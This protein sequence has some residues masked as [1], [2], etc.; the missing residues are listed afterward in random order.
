[1]DASLT[2]DGAFEISLGVAGFVS[3]LGVLANALNGGFSASGE[4][5]GGAAAPQIELS[6]S[7]RRVLPLRPDSAERPE[8]LRERSPVRMGS[9]TAVDKRGVWLEVAVGSRDRALSVCRE[10]LEDVDVV[11]VR[12]SS[13]LRGMGSG[14]RATSGMRGD[15]W[16][17]ARVLG[18]RDG[19]W[20]TERDAYLSDAEER[21]VTLS[22]GELSGSSSSAR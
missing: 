3:C 18:W 1:M 4:D 14:T 11:R 17:E 9:G 21:T 5:T 15:A 12:S 6:V 20:E 22:S 2:G 19:T 7:P 8:T 16:A 13:K 10:V